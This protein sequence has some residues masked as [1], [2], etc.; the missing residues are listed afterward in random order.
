MTT[1]KK[2]S[3]I[4]I[5]GCGAIGSRIARSIKNEL[6]NDCLLTSLYD[7]D[8]A[9]SKQLAGEITSKKIVKESLKDLIKSC[10]FVVEAVNAK[11]TK[12]IIRTAL[13]AKKN[14]LAMSVGK[15]LNAADLFQLAKKN[16]CF[17]LLPSG[18]ISGLDAIKAA[19]LTGISSVTLTTRKPPSGFSKSTHIIEKGIDLNKI[20]SE[21]VIFD[22]DVDTA[23]KLFPENINVAATVAL[24]CGTKDKMRV[25]IITAPDFQRN[26]HEVDI[27]GD[28]GRMVSRTENVVCP[29][30]PK[31]SYLAV[32]SAIQTLKQ[33]FNVIKIGT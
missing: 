25:R 17:I 18:A 5:V 14:V 26:S 10:D 21:T 9:K 13:Q 23:V 8:E 2:K 3:R 11:D 1:H 12:E 22:G 27:I 33:F 19:A 29:D 15:L 30:N 24:A 7:I 31:T 16:H 28:F 4:G 32:L 20:D 6:K